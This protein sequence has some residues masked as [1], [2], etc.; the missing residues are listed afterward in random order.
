MLHDGLCYQGH[1]VM[2]WWKWCWPRDKDGGPWAELNIDHTRLAEF[3]ELGHRYEICMAVLPVDVRP[4]FSISI[5]GFSDTL[6]YF[7]KTWLKERT[8]HTDHANDFCLWVTN[9][10]ISSI[11]L[12]DCMM[13]I[14]YLFLR[15]LFHRE[16]NSAWYYNEERCVTDM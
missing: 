11:F 14:H 4:P 10:V 16:T 13:T 12:K 7:P 15:H 8:G 9:F 1:I 6:F 5:W 3:L 2:F